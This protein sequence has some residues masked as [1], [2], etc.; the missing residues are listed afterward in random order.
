[1]ATTGKA[2][3]R[4]LR[5]R[6]EGDPLRPE[7]AGRARSGVAGEVPVVDVLDDQRL[8]RVGHVV[9][10]DAAD[11]LEPD[12]RLGSLADDP[13][14]DAL[15]LGALVSLRVSNELFEAWSELNCPGTLVIRS[16]L[17]PLSKT[18]S[19]PAVQIEKERA[20]KE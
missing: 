9:D 20:P 15:G 13:D 12:E 4:A 1:M 11:S 17:S 3:R 7:V 19:I 16:S 14:L 5:A 18:R 6:D 8:A 2:H 10:D